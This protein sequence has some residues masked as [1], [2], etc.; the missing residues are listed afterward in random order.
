MCQIVGPGGVFLRHLFT[1][2]FAMRY[3]RLSYSY[4]QTRLPDTEYTARVDKFR[5][6]V[7]PGDRL[8]IFVQPS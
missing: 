1:L 5:D 7:S 3:W 4:A 2:S 6:D 8:N